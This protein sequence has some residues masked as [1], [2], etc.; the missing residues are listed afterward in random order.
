MIS[1][2]RSSARIFLSLLLSVLMVWATTPITYAAGPASPPVA[3][4]KPLGAL[5]TGGQAEVRG[6]AVRYET[7]L[8][9][10]DSIKTQGTTARLNLVGGT[11]VDLT[12]YS[13]G[14]IEKIDGVPTIVLK[15]GVAQFSNAAPFAMKIGNLRLVADNA[16]ASV[17]ALGQATSVTV[18][19]GSLR[20]I[21]EQTQQV[22]QLN[23][24]ESTVFGKTGEPLGTVANAANPGGGSPRPRP[25][26]G[27]TSGATIAAIAGIAAGV[28]GI[29]VGTVAHSNA[30]DANDRAAA[31]QAQAS[32]LASTIQT[33]QST[34]TT[35]QA[36]ITTL[37]AQ[38]TALTATV[39]T[40]Q[41]QLNTARAQLASL[42]TFNAQQRAAVDQILVLIN[43]T[44]A[45][46]AQ[47]L[48]LQQQINSAAAQIA[49]AQQEIASILA[50]GAAVT[51]GGQAVLTPAQQAR[52]NVLLAL[53]A[54]LTVQLATATTQQNAIVA[55]INAVTVQIAAII[56]NLPPL[57][58]NISP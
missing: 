45:L 32:S 40:L 56:N 13:E 48:A 29:I 52:L 28:A 43:Q 25:A 12:L 23:A 46:Q 14:T 7:T 57:P 18:K 33:L 31:A 44:N 26:G 20:A 6:M 51:A 1:L 53:L 2:K 22:S 41:T 19:S 9:E 27:G 10:G 47:L 11:R 50:A 36:S 3:P 54:T 16:R 58:P 21:N 15:Q 55:Q 34:I 24:G 8:F 4:A 37:T 39:T 35:L 5:V 49:S 30:N 17:T 42:V 38:N